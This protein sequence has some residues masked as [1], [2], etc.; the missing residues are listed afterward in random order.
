MAN[1]IKQKELKT[2][3]DPLVILDSTKYIGHEQTL[4]PIEQSLVPQRESVGI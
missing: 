3:Y 2:S 4:E 1:T